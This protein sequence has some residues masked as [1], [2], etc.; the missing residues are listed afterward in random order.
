MDGWNTIFSFWGPAYFQV[1]LLLVSG[2]VCSHHHSSF[3]DIKFGS[4]HSGF[5]MVGG[6]YSL[7]RQLPRV[8]ENYKQDGDKEENDHDNFGGFNQAEKYVPQPGNLTQMRGEHTRNMWS[9]HVYQ[10]KLT[11]RDW[12]FFT[13]WCDILEMQH[14]YRIQ[15]IM[16]LDISFKTTTIWVSSMIHFQEFIHINPFKKK[17]KG[18]KGWNFLAN[19]SI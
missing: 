7:Q 14:G 3:C 9:H 11:Q 18:F 17:N 15:T 10:V 4:L 16:F 5:N 13:I 2:S 6:T 19:K 8:H 1:R 12:G